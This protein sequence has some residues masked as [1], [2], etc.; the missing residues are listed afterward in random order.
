[1]NIKSFVFSLFLIFWISYHCEA[2]TQQIKKTNDLIDVIHYSIYLDNINFSTKVL[3]AN[4]EIRLTPKQNNTSS[5]QLD[6]LNF[7]V[8]S[9]FLNT[10]RIQN[11]L[12]NDSIINVNLPQAL[13]IIDTVNLRIYYHGIPILE[14]YQWGGFHIDGSYAYNLGV[15]FEAYPHNYGKAWFPCLDNFTDRA[16]YDYYIT[17]LNNHKA[18][19]GG[20]LISVTPFNSNTKTFHWKMSNNIP[21]YLASVAIGSYAAILDT[22]N[23][24]N[25]RIP[26]GIYVRPTDS[27]RA[28]NSFTNLKS[29]LTIFEHFMG[30]Y[31]WERVGYVGTTKGAMEH[32]CN[33]AYPNSSISGNSSNEWLY[34]HELS[35]H[36]FGDLVTCATQ[37]DMWINEG[38]ATFCESLYREGLYGKQSY[39]TNMHNKMKDVLYTT[40][41]KD[42]GYYALYGIPETLTYGST[43]YDK[44]AVV[45]H[46]LRNYLGDTLFFNAVKSF[47]N[48]YAYKD[49]SS[50]N[51]RDYF[52]SFTGVNLTDFFDAWVFTPGFPHFSVDSF[53]VTNIS[54]PI[55][56]V[57]VFVRQKHL[58]NNSYANSNKAELT[59]IGQYWE[60]FTDTIRFSGQTGNA[61]FFMPFVPVAVI[62]DLDEKIADATIDN[63]QTIKT[64]GIKTFPDT[65]FGFEVS[66][67]DDSALVR[68]EHNIVSPDTMKTPIQG[69][70]ISKSHYWKI[71]GI[72]PAAFIG[73]GKFTYSQS[74]FDKDLI[75]HSADSLLIL[76]RENAKQEWQFINYTRTGN[77]AAGYI[78]TDSIRKGEYT[79]AIWDW[80]LYNAIDEVHS[81]KNKLLN[82]YP[83]PSNDSFTIAFSFNTKGSLRIIN[84]SGQTIKTFEVKPEQTQLNWK[85]NSLK[86]GIY[87]IE[88]L[89]KN[90]NIIE[91]KK[92]IFTKTI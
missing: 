52:S 51:M 46:T 47:L 40:N 27:L 58:G 64:T 21:T 42:G 66:H 68:V 6:L 82:V 16:T 7:T 28:T 36:W 87:I 29:I 54:Q 10:I 11:Y 72:F 61:S 92:V 37:E 26:I 79:F 15:A 84:T 88:L 56:K 73:K 71:D 78:Y 3:T 48:Y 55:K 14:P 13:N 8:D 75:L 77:Y 70:V 53:V 2:Q 44:G 34:A 91:R 12:F 17:V 4:T 1:M 69:L 38:W 49:V 30:P 80:N 85:P 67:I 81:S 50:I 76:Y 19:C 41:I 9:M 23:G 74:G 86:S 62:L 45:V 18:I 39:K 65:Y 35:H 89:N 24:I 57:N 83:N 20:T 22:F 31:K 63:Y 32:A 59:F 5:F 43:V 90:N 33:I 60:K 25:G